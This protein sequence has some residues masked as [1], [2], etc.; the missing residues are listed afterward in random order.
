MADILGYGPSHTKI[1]SDDVSKV[2]FYVAQGLA[3]PQSIEDINRKFGCSEFTEAREGVTSSQLQ[4]FCNS[5]YANASSWDD[6]EFKMLD[7]ASQ[8]SAFYADLKEYGGGAVELIK[9]I[10]GYENYNK[11]FNELAEEDRVTFYMK[12]DIT[13]ADAAREY[14]DVDDFVQTVVDSI[15]AKRKKTSQVKEELKSFGDELAKIEKD[16]GV[17]LNGVVKAN[18]SERLSDISTKL[19]E[20]NDR[21]NKLRKKT[22]FEWWEWTI[23]GLYGP[24]GVG[25]GFTIKAGRDAA[26]NADIQKERAKERELISEQETIIKI[27]ADLKILQ[28]NLSSM[29]IYVAGAIEGV[30]QLETL[31]SSTLTEIEE[32][33]STLTRQKEWKFLHSFVNKM[34]SVLDRWDRINKNVEDLKKAL[35]A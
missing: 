26:V 20:I 15:E 24:V 3:L 13:D 5:V 18:A 14:D 10:P 22:A 7:V 35:L 4:G 6:I 32:S 12:V 33:K 1:T 27:M 8:L 28:S 9:K 2:K 34:E 16:L 31:W 29:V 17:R 21:I 23:C 19:I 11:K 25:V 30:T